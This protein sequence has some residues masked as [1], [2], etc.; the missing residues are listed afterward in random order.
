M[1]RMNFES[2]HN[3]YERLVTAEITATLVERDGI[4]DNDFLEDVACVALNQ[5]PAR[6]VRHD[7]DTAFYL[8][9][10]EREQ[11]QHAVV[12]AVKTAFEHVTRHR[13]E[14]RPNTIIQ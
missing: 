3:Y 14:Q 12:E 2:I 7:V 10:R 8:S 9:S 4:R 13:G 5:L 11:M 1:P 6:Y